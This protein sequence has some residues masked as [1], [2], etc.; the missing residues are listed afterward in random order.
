MNNESLLYEIP[1]IYTALAQWLACLIYIIPLK[2]RNKNGWLVAVISLGLFVQVGINHIAGIYHPRI[3]LGFML[4]SFLAMCMLIWTCLEVSI[5]EMGFLAIRAFI[6]AEFAASFE[7][8]IFYFL[9]EKEYATRA[10]SHLC[11]VV[12][13]CAVFISLLFIEKRHL[14]VRSRLFISPKE[15]L[16]SALIGGVVFLMSNLSFLHGNTPFSSSMNREIFYIRTLV[17]FVG[18]VMLYAQLEMRREA[19]LKHE[20]AAMDSILHKQYEIYRISKENDELINRKYHDLK[21]QIEIIRNEND[22]EKR[23]VY[24]KEIDSAIKQHQAENQTGNEVLDTIL[25]GK[26]LYCAENQINFTCVAD[27]K[28]LNFMEV[29]DICTIF[30]NALDNAIESVEKI[31][32]AEKRLIS[33]TVSSQNSFVLI[34][35]DNYFESTIKMEEG[36]PLT[37]KKD[38]GNHGYGIKSIRLTAEKYGG[39]ATVHTEDKWFSLL[40]LLPLPESE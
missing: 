22:P 24:L 12:I 40:V 9:A 27:G 32:D 19:D 5:T 31:K 7:W 1:K 37:T 18:V 16:N 36:M 8:Q 20:L 26:S 23:E 29:M 4:F 25:F 10:F 30:G 6:V 21:H 33:M 2:K 3:W 38:A 17:D 14:P 13:Y 28:L 34:R 11:V 35:F 39:S 15:V